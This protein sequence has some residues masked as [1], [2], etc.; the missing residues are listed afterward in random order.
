MVNGVKIAATQTNMSAIATQARKANC[1]MRSRLSLTAA[2]TAF[3]IAAPVAARA[4][5]AT[6]VTQTVPTVACGSDY[7]QTEPGTFFTFNGNTV[8]LQG[9]PFGPGLTDTIV[10]RTADLPI[11][12]VFAAP[13]LLITGLQLEST[14]PVP[15]IGTI[16][17]SLDPA[18][19]TNNTS[20]MSINGGLSGGTLTS[21]LN[22]FSTSAPSPA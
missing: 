15:G 6:E 5:P 19:L 4:C 18:N 7:S 10:E 1:S 8:A 20:T 9:V 21:S 17:A 2:L 22:V 16:F 14:A 12:A 13:N 3:V 11:N